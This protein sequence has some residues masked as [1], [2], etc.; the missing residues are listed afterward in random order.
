[1]DVVSVG[2]PEAWSVPPFA[3]EI[4]DGFLFGRGA[5]DMKGAVAAFFIAVEEAL[6]ALSNVRIGVIITTDEE[7]AAINGTR[8]VLHWLCQQNKA[9]EAF[10]VAEPS[11]PDVLGSHIKIGRRGSLVGKLVAE[12]VQGHAAYP[13]RFINPNRALALASTVLQAL[14]WRDATACMPATQFQPVALQAGSFQASAI[15]PGRAEGLWNIRFTPQQPPATLVTRLREALADPPPWVL[16]HP[17]AALLARVAVH[18]NIDTA[19]HPY[20]SHNGRLTTA[21]V[22][23][24]AKVLGREPVLDCGGGTSDGRFVQQFFPDAE[25]IE[26]GPAEGG[27]LWSAVYGSASFRD[28]GGMHQV[29]ERISLND[30]ANLR[31]IYCRLICDYAAADPAAALE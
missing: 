20:L 2:N 5:T 12:G 27:G 10:L 19:S 29:D 7:W 16:H 26:L 23:A 8:H 31:R 14:V 11:S 18:G 24:A 3:G 13:D 15:I 30:L 28:R 22:S 6:P 25:V 4:K 1:T 17:D 21:A 9:F